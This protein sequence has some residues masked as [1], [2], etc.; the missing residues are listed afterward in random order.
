MVITVSDSVSQHLQATDYHLGIRYVWPIPAVHSAYPGQSLINAGLL[1]NAPTTP[2]WAIS[3]RT[4]ELFRQLRLVKPNFSIMAFVRSMCMAHGR[5]TTTSLSEKFSTAFDLYLRL[6]RNLDARVQA[7]LGRDHTHH[8]KHF[9]PACTHSVPGESEL[10]YQFLWTMDGGNSTKR[11]KD[12]GSASNFLTF[13]GDKDIRIR[14]EAVD[15]FKDVVKQ[16]KLVKKKK[17]GKKRGAPGEC[18][19]FP[20]VRRSNL[21]FCLPQNQIL[22]TRTWT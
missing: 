6:L 5:T 1:S 9:C 19:W 16:R 20:S 15:A 8:R 17:R 4:L 22:K 3:I 10:K 21:I 14:P 13:T 2:R 11:W 12:A 7:S 18:H